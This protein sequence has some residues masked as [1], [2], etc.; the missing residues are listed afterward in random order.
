MTDGLRWGDAY[1]STIERI[2]AQDGD[3]PRF[4]MSALMWISHAEMPLTADELC[5]ALAVEL[6]SRVFNAGNAPSIATVVGCC[7]GLIA[8]DKR[9]SNVRLIHPTLKEYL[10]ARPDIF[11]R[12]HSAMAEICLTYL[13]SKE[14]KAISVDSFCDILDTPFLDYSSLYWG[15]HAKKDLSNHAT[16]LALELF[17]EYDGHISS[18]LLPARVF[19][20]DFLNFPGDCGSHSG[21]DDSLPFS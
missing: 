21:S 17:R 1:S 13:N 2:K 3:K 14:V 11:I 5:H 6:G 20:R 12:P 18:K 19:V 4:G 16:S 7:Q 10:C 8:V 9:T 15:V